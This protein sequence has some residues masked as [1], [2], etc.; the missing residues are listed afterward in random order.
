MFLEHKEVGEVQ[1]HR[2]RM[3]T[4]M[5]FSAAIRLGCLVVPE[6]H[7]FCGCAVGAG[8]FILTGEDLEKVQDFPRLPFGNG[9]DIVAK[10]TGIPLE[11]VAHASRNHQRRKWTREQCADYFEAQG[12]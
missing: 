5:K 10:L 1:P 11:I 4:P 9:D 6:S 2:E 7:Q 12:Y 8:Y 3:P